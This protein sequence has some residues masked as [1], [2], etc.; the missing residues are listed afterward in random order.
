MNTTHSPAYAFEDRVEEHRRLI[1]QSVLFDPLTE[2]LLAAAGVQPGMRV[3][4]L[5]TGAGSVALLAA[6]MVGPSGAVVTVD[7]DAEALALAADHAAREGVRNIEFVEGD[8]GVP[9]LP[10]GYFDAI[11][12]RL[13]LMYLPAPAATLYAAARQLR[14]GGVLCC[15]ELSLNPLAAAPEP[16]LIGR[17]HAAIRTTFELAGARAD[18]GLELHRLIAEAGLPAPELHG[19]T[20]LACGPEAPVWAWGGVA[21][22]LLPLMQRLGVE[23]ADDVASADLDERMLAELCAHDAVLIAPMMVGARTRVRAA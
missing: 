17:V 14:P 13:V 5:G 22:G 23:G 1:E 9:E 15:Q 2:R 20:L 16:P 6:R 8:L 10:G 12:S 4:D 21:R 18:L 11:V 19:E 7:R 3:L